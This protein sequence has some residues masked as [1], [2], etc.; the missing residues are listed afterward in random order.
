[1]CKGK[2]VRAHVDTLMLFVCMPLHVCAYVYIRMLM[3]A[4]MH[5]GMHHVCMYFLNV[6]QL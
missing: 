6:C 5:S 3:Y 1:M 4:C 2:H